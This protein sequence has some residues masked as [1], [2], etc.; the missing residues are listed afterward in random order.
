[1]RA[2]GKSRPLLRKLGSESLLSFGNVILIAFGIDEGCRSAR[3]HPR[4]FCFQ[5]EI[6]AVRAE[7]N[8]TPQRLQLPEHP[9]IVSR[10]LRIASVV[11]EL[12][13]RI[14]VR[15]AD[16]HSVAGFAGL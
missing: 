7:K 2:A 16:D 1:M 15:A 5:I 3:F 11:Y 10:N 14:H 9:F 4:V 8:V 12:I 6:G 13:A